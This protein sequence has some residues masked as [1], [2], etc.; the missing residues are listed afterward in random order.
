MTKE[1]YE[2][3]KAKI[4]ATLGEPVRDFDYKNESARLIDELKKQ[5]QETGKQE[6]KGLKEFIAEVPKERL[7]KAAAKALPPMYI[8][9]H[10]LK[11]FTDLEAAVIVAHYADRSLNN[12]EL[13]RQCNTKRQTV[14]ALFH[15]Q[16]FKVL[17]AKYFDIEMPPAAQNAALHLVHDNDQKTT[18][19]MM[20]HYG[21]IKAEKQDINITSKPIED[22]AAMKML[23]ELGDKLAGGDK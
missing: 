21:L 11:G 14:T 18:L 6:K 2:I 8:A 20:E 17:R 9:D 12:E 10:D 7:A 15:S 5:R 1:E 19:R 22:P 4:I 23:R 16:A 3:E 13:A